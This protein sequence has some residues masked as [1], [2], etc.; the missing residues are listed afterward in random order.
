MWTITFVQ[1]DNHRI[2]KQP[3]DRLS[4]RQCVGWAGPEHLTSSMM[5]VR[6]AQ[7]CRRLLWA[8]IFPASMWIQESAGWLDGCHTPG[9][10]HPPPPPNH[11]LPP[12][13]AAST[14]SFNGR[15][16]VTPEC[17]PVFPPETSRPHAAPGILTLIIWDTLLL[18]GIYQVLTNCWNVSDLLSL[19]QRKCF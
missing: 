4:H 15:V 11:R 10:P 8:G 14:V 6:G 19:L 5:V 17:H 3:L 16:N 12:T 7:P 13:P 1:Y 18:K 9:L 2:R